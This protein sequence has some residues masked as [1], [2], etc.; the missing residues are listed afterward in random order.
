MGKTQNQDDQIAA[1]R[2]LLARLCAAD[3]TLTEA[4]MLRQEMSR[5][6]EAKSAEGLTAGSSMA[7]IRVA[8]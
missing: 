1:M 2:V 4:A 3:L 7:S 5:L 8:C 6:L